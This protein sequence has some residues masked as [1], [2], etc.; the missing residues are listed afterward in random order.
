[1]AEKAFPYEHVQLTGINVNKCAVRNE[2]CSESPSTIF[3]ALPGG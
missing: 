3:L 2:A 1:M